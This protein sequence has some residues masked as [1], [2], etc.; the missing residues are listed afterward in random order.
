M[1]QL[2]ILTLIIFSSAV[3]AQEK[4]Y[5]FLYDLHQVFE[6]KSNN[7]TDVSE[8]VKEE[9]NKSFELEV[10]ANKNQSFIKLIDVVRNSQASVFLDIKPEPNWL[11]ID[12]ASNLTYEK[13]SN[14]NQSFKF[15]QD[16]IQRIQVQP[17][18]QEKTVLG[19]HAKEYKAETEKYDYTFWLG[20]FNGITAS[21][22]YFQFKDLIVV[23]LKIIFKDALE[24]GNKREITYQLKDKKEATFNF[25]KNIPKKYT[26]K[27]ELNKLNNE[28]ESISGV[29]KD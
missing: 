16:S 21:P 23:E 20:D 9:L 3:F 8:A 12:K 28:L 19:I 27:E 14:V 13:A 29:E 10:F 17:T 25:K 6:S 5:R 4:T 1:K 26:T 15:L 22:I 11:L 18:G 7:Q 2:L 24:N